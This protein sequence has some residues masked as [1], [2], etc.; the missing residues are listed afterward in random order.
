[1]E[2]AE[3]QAFACYFA[4]VMGMWLMYGVFLVMEEIVKR[5]KDLDD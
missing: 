1:M 5:L 2:D 4:F 3:A